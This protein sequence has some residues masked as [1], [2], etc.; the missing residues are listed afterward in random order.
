[1][2]K[3]FFGSFEKQ[4]RKQR[5]LFVGNIIINTKKLQTNLISTHLNWQN[6]STIRMEMQPSNLAFVDEK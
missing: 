1:M 5:K 6:V 3:N 4:K 2:L